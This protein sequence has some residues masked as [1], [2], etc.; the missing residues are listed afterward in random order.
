V[1]QLRTATNNQLK[2]A[3]APRGRLRRF[4]SYY[5]PYRLT[6]IAVLACAFVSAAITLLY[7]L[8]TRYV[9]KTVLAGD[10]VGA[11][12]EILK[13]GAAMVALIIVQTICSHVY[14]Y[15]GHAMGAQMESDL[16]M[17]LFEHYQRL[18]LS[19]YDEQRT[20]ELMSRL[21]NDLF[22][23]AEMYHHF[24]EDVIMNSLK[25]LGAGFILL[26]IN[27]R[28][29][30]VVFLF[31]TFVAAFTL[32]FSGKMHRA[33]S[34][35]KKRIGQ[36]NAQVEDSLSG[37][38]VVKSFAAEEMEKEKFA[39]ENLLFRQSRTNI[40]RNESYFSQGVN[41]LIQLITT[42]VVVVGGISIVGGSLDLADLVTFLL[43]IGHLVQP[44]LRLTTMVEQYQ[45]GITGFER[46]MEIMEVQP[47]IQDTPGTAELS[48][49]QGHVEFRGVG[50]RYRGTNDYVLKDLSFQ[51]AAGEYIAVVGVSGV[52]KTTLCS[53][54]PRFYEVTEGSI[55][56][57]G[58]DIRDISLHSLRRSIGVVQQDVY[59]FA[60]TVLDNIRYGRPEADFEEVVAAAKQADA[61]EFIM[62]LPDGYYTQVGQ[63][64]VRL[65]GGQKQRLSIARV[66]L[67]DPPVLIFDEATSALDSESEQAVQESLEKLAKNRT[68]FVI[69]H[70][71]S[72]IRRAQRIIVL[73]S[74]RIVEQGTH[75]ELLRL[76]GTYARLHN[77]QFQL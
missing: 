35:N 1:Q 24:P 62:Q 53:L 13:V 12:E 29:T 38:R 19:F 5:K 3:S 76:G 57:D 59:L 17:E 15:H 61:H 48:R 31:L 71:L 37:M 42:A 58:I 30:A 55:L 6:F 43:Y 64:G 14:D 23:L 63:R 40:Y 18:S 66:F 7:P 69:A 20:G 49:I 75:E 9:T 74:G 67:K 34:L 27:A 72:T 11:A 47:D 4:L 46:F 28:L 54:I 32:L 22:S 21:T 16:R 10:L 2:R 8:L 33:Q 52:G 70:R 44:V 56:L 26:R 51:V 45:D 60:G 73:G 68:T 50:F 25:F 77:M 41:A 65:S 36:I 39:R